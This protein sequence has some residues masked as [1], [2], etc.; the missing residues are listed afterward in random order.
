MK[1]WERG[2]HLIRMA[3]EGGFLPPEPNWEAWSRA[4]KGRP[5][6]WLLSA[7]S[8]ESAN[9]LNHWMPA[10]RSS[11]KRRGTLREMVT[12]IQRSRFINEPMT[13]TN[14]PRLPNWP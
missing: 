7:L 13:W 3:A 2:G 14:G 5:E 1:S 12:R 8:R 6:S 10:D 9:R 11:F 4:S